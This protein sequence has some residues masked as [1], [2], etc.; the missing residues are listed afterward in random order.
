M[1]MNTSLIPPDTP[2][3]MPRHPPDISREDKKPTDNNRRQQ[4]LPDILKQHRSVSWGV[5]DCL[6]MSAGACCRLL[7]SC[8]YWIC[9]GGVWSLFGEVSGVSEWYSWK[10][11]A[12]GC[13][14]VVSG[15]SVP[16]VWSYN[17]I[18]AKPW[19]TPF[20]FTWPYWDIKILKCLY[21]RLTKM[22]GFYDFSIF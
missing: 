10:L 7:A 21:I 15:L 13:V 4:T 18:L 20:F 19:K 3:K 6:F 12:L 5:C 2:Q 11:E 1:S 14:W 8:V 16:A 17:T 22:I 9:L